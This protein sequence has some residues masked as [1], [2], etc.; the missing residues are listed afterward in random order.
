MAVQ[1]LS[2][3]KKVICAA[4][5]II[6][7][8]SCRKDAVVK[9]DSSVK[10]VSSDYLRSV[11]LRLRDSLPA[12]VMGRLDTGRAVLTKRGYTL[13]IPFAGK[14]VGEDFVLLR[15]DSVGNVLKGQ[16]VHLDLQG[17]SGSMRLEAL[18]GRVILNSAIENG[19]MRVERGKGN[20]L[21]VASGGKTVT[22]GGKIVTLEPAPG[23]DW[24]QEVIVVGY[25]GGG[26][27][28]S[29]ISLDGLLGVSSGDILGGA[30]GG[31]GDSGSGGDGGGGGS[32]GGSAGG[33]PVTN[34]VGGKFY[35]PL[36]PGDGIGGGGEGLVVDGDVEVEEEYVNDIP[37][38]D[39]RKMF[40]CFDLV[41]SEGAVYTVQLCVDL[42]VN[43]SPDMSMNF[44]G[45]VNAGHTFLVV[46]KSGGG[47]R[48]SQAFGYYPQEAPS[49][50][51][52]FSPIPSVIKD[53]G[54]KEINGSLTMTI[55]AE[56]F[57]IIK[58]AAFNLS[59]LPYT[60]DKSN[61][62][63]YAVNVF[64]TVRPAPLTMD[65]YVLRQGGITVGNGASSPPIEIVIN[66]S[67]QKL[68]RR[69]EEMKK[70]NNPEAANIQ[71]D[72]SH[73]LK[74]PISHGACN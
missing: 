36:V 71:L 69:L 32:D 58:S 41:P 45:G 24:L 39:V 6:F 70:S 38:V 2:N 15:T 22:L 43:S 4:I 27:S 54:N 20:R 50:W 55:N 11:L 40:N 59:S 42:P 35:S 14:S 30:S 68:Y 67:P 19:F 66:N 72:L 64:N 51:N 31:G 73:N 37:V 60:I 52:P 9:V 46:T 7:A 16:V 48:V 74:S 1:N 34:G 63:D 25:I 65:P 3:M 18:G 49:M 17:L 56:Q 10:V 29:F 57:S 26:A 5:L 28:T 8:Y 47:E 23:S 44:S 61:C 13:R 12:D 21:A 53:N 33:A 62:T